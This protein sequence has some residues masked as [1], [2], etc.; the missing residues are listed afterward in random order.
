MGVMKTLPL[1]LGLLVAAVFPVG[2]Q[3]DRPV[4]SDRDAPKETVAANKL[5]TL[6]IAGD[7]TLRSNAPLR[8]WGQDLG[9]FF[10]PTKINVV[11]RAIGGRSSRTFFTEGRWKEIL[12]G[13]KPGDFVI[14]QFGHN[15]VGA[16]DEKGKF[17]GSVKGI[18]DETEKVTKPDGT[19][20]EVRS[21]GWYLREMAR[22]AREKKAKV[23][24]CSPIPHKKFDADGK[25]VRDWAEYRG[26]VEASAKAERAAFLDLAELI[27]KAYDK[28]DPTVIE[29]YFA[30]KGTHTSAA[31][32]LFNAKTVVS[33]LRAIPTAPLDPYLNDAGKEIPAS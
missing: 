30:D 25:F 24:L 29:S 21:Y 17:R 13:I 9:T 6:W 22:S 27:G 4:V 19:V 32:A 23:I 31:G 1:L 7:S 16:L 33:G 2:A 12:A 15:D 11:N 5:P 18:G 26:W 14:I 28:L 20:E 10:D 3:D 8:G